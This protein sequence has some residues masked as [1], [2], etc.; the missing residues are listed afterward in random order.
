MLWAGS[1]CSHEFWR[2]QIRK[3]TPQG[4]WPELAFSESVW[5]RKRRRKRAETGGGGHLEAAPSSSSKLRAEN[6]KSDALRGRGEFPVAGSNGQVSR[7]R[8]AQIAGVVHGKIMLQCQFK[9]RLV[10]GNLD[11]ANRQ[12]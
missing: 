12:R 1:P 7:H 11:D 9:K 6:F 4:L 8:K 5:P 2:S 10:H 3:A